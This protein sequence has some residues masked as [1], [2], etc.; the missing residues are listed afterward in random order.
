MFIPEEEHMIKTF[1]VKE[2]NIL[3]G[4]LTTLKMSV[5]DEGQDK[6][7]KIE[8]QATGAKVK[9]LFTIENGEKTMDVSAG[10]LKAYLIKNYDH[11][12]KSSQKIVDKVYNIGY[13]DGKGGAS[14]RITTDEK[15]ALVE[16]F[17][18]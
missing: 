9:Y 12:E 15:S 2:H 17:F 14:K 5:A 4:K 16:D 7:D 18:A 11:D 6:A 8:C 13:N 3:D 10:V 1:N